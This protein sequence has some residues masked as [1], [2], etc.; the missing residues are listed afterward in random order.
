MFVVAAL[1]ALTA[2][3]EASRPHVIWI[4]ADDFGY[5]DLGAHNREN[6][7]AMRTPHL[8]WLAT[9]AHGVLLE[10]AYSQPICSPTRA[11]LMTG[12]YQIRTGLQHGVIWPAQPNGLPLNESTIADRLRALNYSTH[13]VGKWHIGF[14]THAHTP[15]ERGFDT[16]FG[17]WGGGEDYSTHMSSGGFDFRQNGAIF[18]EAA[19][20]YSTKLFSEKAVALIEQHAAGVDSGRPLFLYLAFQATHAPLQAPQH[21][22]NSCAHIADLLLSVGGETS[23]LQIMHLTVRNI[24]NVRK[25]DM[26]HI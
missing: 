14:H 15:L 8:D 24:W 5:N 20:S 17:F 9:S 1:A 18:R 2:V 26:E 25:I 7:N 19:G 6:E 3:S 13:A 23:G 21:F 11:Q 16:F 22:I 4:V 12:R 10:N